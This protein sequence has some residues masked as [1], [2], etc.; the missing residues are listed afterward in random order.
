MA[1]TRKEHGDE[2]AVEEFAKPVYFVAEHGVKQPAYSVYKVDV[3]AAADESVHAR[4]LAR[5]SVTE[6]GMSF[7]AAH[8]KH[9]SWIVGVG[10]EGAPSSS[11]PAHRR[12]STARIL[13]ALSMSPS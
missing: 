6:H 10:G 13:N 5:L 8:S 1:N 3:A 12:C 4:A 9:G 2:E 11:T 7:I